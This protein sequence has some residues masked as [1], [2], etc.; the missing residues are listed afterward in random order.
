MIE[1]KVVG[2]IPARG[3]SKGI[4]NK[5]IVN[6]C[7]KPL[8]HYT[9]DAAIESNVFDNII[10]TTDCNMISR[11][12]KHYK[13]ISI[14][15]RPDDLATDKALTIDAILHVISQQKDN[16]CDIILLQPT[17]PLRKASH[18]K[19]S[20]S[21]F[22][23]KSAK[24]L[25]SI[26]KEMH[27]PFKNFIID[28]NG[29]VSPLFSINHLSLPRQSLPEVA[30]QNGAIYIAHAEDLIKHNSFYIEPAI[31][32]EMSYETSVDIDTKQDLKN[33][34]SRLKSFEYC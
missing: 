29:F 23:R 32:Y 22:K 11:A 20:Y 3:G 17:S 14:V 26:T 12:V 10:V 28:D 25:I 1:R 19:D 15:K 21:L 4:P 24:S 30:R 27:T 18:I 9:I 7:G 16:N 13:D 8:I 5:N 33:V 6:L 31:G 34:E 2:I